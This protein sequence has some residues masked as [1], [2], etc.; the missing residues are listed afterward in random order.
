MRA[1]GGVGSVRFALSSALL[2]VDSLSGLLSL[3]GDAPTITQV[4]TAQVFAVDSSSPPLS[5]RLSLTINIVNPPSITILLVNPQLNVLEGDSTLGVISVIGGYTPDSYSV[6]LAFDGLNAQLGIMSATLTM[7]GRPALITATL[8]A[9]DRHNNTAPASLFLTVRILEGFTLSVAEVVVPV[10][11]KAS[12]VVLATLQPGG[13]SGPYT[14]FICA[15]VFE[16]RAMF[17]Y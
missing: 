17:Y 2:G 7:R 12:N 10:S 3:A 11:V 16:D 4:Q 5:A 8:T 14:I 1:V 6:S 13:V 9:D 15:A